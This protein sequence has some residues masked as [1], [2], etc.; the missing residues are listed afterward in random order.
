MINYEKFIEELSKGIVEGSIIKIKLGS[1]PEKISYR[2]IIKD[3]TIDVR[4]KLKIMGSCWEIEY[5]PNGDISITYTIQN[6][7]KTLLRTALDKLLKNEKPFPSSNWADVGPGGK[8]FTSSGIEDS[9]ATLVLYPDSK[10]SHTA[11]AFRYLDEYEFTTFNKQENENMYEIKHTVFIKDI[12]SF[13]DPNT[14]IEQAEKA[15]L[16]LAGVKKAITE[17][18]DEVALALVEVPEVLTQKFNR[19]MDEIDLAV[20]TIV[21]ITELPEEDEE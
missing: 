9:G 19:Q 17:K 15:L 4:K 8:G 21:E 18:F 10:K 11:G 3:P 7:S 5:H 2:F 14:N 1:I 13:A 12:G 16:E 20:A 6:I